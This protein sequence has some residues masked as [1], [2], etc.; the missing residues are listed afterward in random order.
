MY[1]WQFIHNIWKLLFI[2][3]TR[4]KQ[5]E[6]WGIAYLKALEIEYSGNFDP[7]LI[8]KVARYQSIQLHYVANT[9]SGLYNR[10]NNKAET[11]RNIQY[12]LMTVLYDELTDDQ[13]MDEQRVYEISYH[14]QKVVPVNFK[15]RVL[16]AMH[17]NLIAQ[18]SNKKEYWEIIK[19]VHLA[20]KDSAKQFDATISLDEL[21]DITKRKGGYSLL[22]CRHYLIDP[23]NKQVDNCWYELGGLIQMTN[24]LYDTYKDT[25]EGIHTFANQQQ[26]I[27]N[28]EIIYAKQ[29]SLFKKSI[30]SLA[31]SNYTKQQFAIKT[32]IIPAFGDIAINQLK[33]LQS[34]S[35]SLPNFNQIPR[36]SLIIDMEKMINKYRLIK[37]AYKNGKLWM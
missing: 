21:I 7:A 17:L 37:Y 3:F 18:V 34:N 19:Q 23:I 5:S 24:D 28:I 36:K 8:K 16:L 11:E 33:E 22:M 10:K 12:F 9:F 30:E 27:A 32:S 25:K 6:K 13:K 26:D 1:F 31:V 35:P 14:P 29:K 2:S 4:L 15:E 20:Q